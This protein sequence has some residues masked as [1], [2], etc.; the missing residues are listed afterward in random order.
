MTE[1]HSALIEVPRE[2]VTPLRKN[3]NKNSATRP[4]HAH[5]LVQPSEA[6]IQIIFL[7]QMAFY[8]AVPVIFPQIERRISKYAIQRIIAERCKQFHAVSLV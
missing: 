7:P 5:A 4:K 2:V 6:P 8:I 3:V 1:L